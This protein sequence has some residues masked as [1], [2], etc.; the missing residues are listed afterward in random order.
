MCRD[1][2]VVHVLSPVEVYLLPFPSKR[3][4]WFTKDETAWLEQQ[5]NSPAMQRELRDAN[6]HYRLSYATAKFVD[7]YKS[8]YTDP[9][10]AESP[11]AFKKRKKNEKNAD[12][13]QAMHPH[14]AETRTEFARRL[15]TLSEPMYKWLNYQ[16][17]TVAKRR[18]QPPEALPGTPEPI[19]VV[20]LPKPR[21]E[22]AR[23]AFDMFQKAAPCESSEGRFPLAQ[24]RKAC[25]EACA[26]LAP[27]EQ[28][29][30]NDK[31]RRFNE[32]LDR[33]DASSSATPAASPAGLPAEAIAT[34]LDRTFDVLHEHLKWGGLFIVGGADRDGEPVYY[35]DRRGTNR[36][37]QSF[38][39]ALCTLIHWT[40][41]EFERIVALWLEQCRTEPESSDN[42]A[43]ASKARNILEMMRAGDRGG[44]AG[45]VDLGLTRPAASST[46][47]QAT[48]Q[49]L[50]ASVAS[51][52]SRGDTQQPTGSSAL[53]PTPASP[54]RSTPTQRSH[55]P[56]THVSNS[57]VGTNH[58]GPGCGDDS[59]DEDTFTI[60]PAGPSA[61]AHGAGLDS[62]KDVAASAATD[63]SKTARG[64]PSLQATTGGLIRPRVKARR[65]KKAQETTGVVMP[66]PDPDTE[67]LVLSCPARI[68][69]L[70]NRQ[71]DNDGLSTFT[72][73]KAGPR[74][75]AKQKAAESVGQAAPARG[76]RAR[77]ARQ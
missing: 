3:P 76:K 40:P 25:E 61:P 4:M 18:S 2:L 54:L 8:H 48:I 11:A 62:E 20:P 21:K 16:L 73:G 15:E 6:G 29:E 51:S 56:S 26:T 5:L 14:P 34:W 44:G 59:G 58:I 43:F 33:A 53:S 52:S 65:V 45:A 71:D 39:S 10:P 47:A 30:F 28:A 13:R 75:L 50:R 72:D 17:N 67:T 38:L 22:R 42:A 69:K 63:E 36:H 9:R 27:E 1:L 46:S 68:R 31:A 7:L 24:F 12:K 55:R 57:V 41:E 49:P 66:V 64:R 35:I 19:A 77:H 74:D 70:R 23:T 60:I 32:E 37:G